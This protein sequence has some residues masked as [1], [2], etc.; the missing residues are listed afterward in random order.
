MR[1][2]AR[3]LVASCTLV[4]VG[5]ASAGPLVVAPNPSVSGSA[6]APVAVATATPDPSRAAP[7][8]TPAAC[9]N[10]SVLAGWSTRR[11]G[12]LTVAVPAQETSVS[13]V[14]SEVAAGVGGVLL[15]GSKAPTNLGTQLKAL[16]THVPGRRG[17][18]VM[19]DEEGGGIQRMANLVG[20]LPWAAWMGKNWTAA[21]IRSHVAAVAAR[22][23]AAGVTMD[24]APVLDVDGR[25]EA[26]SRTNPDGWRSFSGRTTTVTRDGLAYLNGL[27]DG[28]VIPVVKHFPGIGHSTYNSDDGTAYALAWSTLK[29]VGL[30]PFTAAI[31]AGTPAVMVSNDIVPGLATN[32]ASLSPTTITY[33]LRGQLGFRGL[34]ITDSLTAKAVTN[35][36]YTLPQAAV[37]ALRSGADM[38]TFSGTTSVGPRTAAIADAIVAAVGT[39]RLSRARLV[40]AAAH[41]LGVR[42]VRLCG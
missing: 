11:L 4:L 6:A 16:E 32:I 2:S 14:Q 41:V 38:V 27:R 1:T 9:T 5:C 25:N 42:H 3:S 40:D 26:P 33:E 37:Q 24:L 18:L 15:F 13:S 30:P 39:G 28:H 23:S 12:L 21:Q 20:S 34:V 17:L 29:Q 22:M 35:A 7:A 8:A 10:R 36:G 31:A 19:T